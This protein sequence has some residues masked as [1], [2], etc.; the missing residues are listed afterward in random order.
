MG[1]K[2][3]PFEVEAFQKGINN[4]LAPHKVYLFPFTHNLLDV[5]IE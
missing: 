1:S 4:S 2:F 3:F 5:L